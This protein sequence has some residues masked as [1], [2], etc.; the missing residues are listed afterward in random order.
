M[1][2]SMASLMGGMVLLT[3]VSF[4]VVAGIALMAYRRRDKSSRD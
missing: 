1:D 3:V 4:L 2:H